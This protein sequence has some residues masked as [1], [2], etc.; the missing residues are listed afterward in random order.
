MDKINDQNYLGKLFINEVKGALNR[1]GS[2]GSSGSGKLYRHNIHL[3]C[4]WRKP[5]DI[6]F[7]IYNADPTN[8]TVLSTY[9]E[10]TDEIIEAADLS[11]F[12]KILEGLG[13]VPAT[14][15]ADVSGTGDGTMGLVTDVFWG[16]PTW[17]TH[18]KD[19]MF[20]AAVLH[21][22]YS[23]GT[24]EFQGVYYE[25]TTAYVYAEN[26][27]D[28]VTE[29][30]SATSSGGDSDSDSGESEG[31]NTMYKHLITVTYE[32]DIYGEPVTVTSIFPVY[33]TDS[34]SCENDYGRLF[35]L[36][37]ANGPL[38][39]GVVNLPDGATR[40]IIS[41]TADEEFYELFI[42]CDDDVM[43]Y[44]VLS[45][46]WSSITDTVQAVPAE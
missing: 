46:N 5:V 14:G 13:R 9:D 33:S 23:V 10:D 44:N 6:Y 18:I 36:V 26:V 2:G 7:E 39:E 19:A 8:Y 16:S 41:V 15:F 1:G 37:L 45:G 17:N 11:A 27:Y 35:A 20:T 30:S 38:S 12:D 25:H 24:G 4:S 40:N 31:N 3:N 29:I 28:T 42:E 22:D 21:N 34:V 43:F 32:S